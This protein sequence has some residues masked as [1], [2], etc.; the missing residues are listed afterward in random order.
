M[1]RLEG[2]AVRAHC[3][4]HVADII[5]AVRGDGCRQGL[6]CRGAGVQLC[7]EVQRAPRDCPPRTARRGAGDHEAHALA[8]RG[9]IHG[10]FSS[11]QRQAGQARGATPPA[12]ARDQPARRPTP[13]P[14]A[15][16]AR[17]LLHPPTDRDATMMPARA[18]AGV[19]S[20]GAPAARAVARVRACFFSRERASPPARTR[21]E[22]VPRARLPPHGARVLARSLARP[23][24]SRT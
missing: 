16:A 12:A 2:S 22:S 10:A 5:L 8:S 23:L 7:E 1:P 18:C 11:L 4:W 3:C 17:R 15:R 13:H 6:R 21:F 14:P 20:E 24:L 9:V 19:A